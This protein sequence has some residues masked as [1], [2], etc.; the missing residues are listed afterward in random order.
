MT[1]IDERIKTALEQDTKE[2]DTLLANEGGL[3]DMISTSFKGGM[4]RWMVL[5]WIVTF[6]V[7]VLMFWCIYNFVMAGEDNIFWGFC[8]LGLMMMQIALKQWTWLEM[9]RATT[10]REIKRL[11]LVIATLSAKLDKNS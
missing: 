1:T 2:L 4:R 9:N 7:T 11:E 10:M 5:V 6:I 3:P 8:S